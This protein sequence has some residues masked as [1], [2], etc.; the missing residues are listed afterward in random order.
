MARALVYI[1]RE[2]LAK[3]LQRTGGIPEPLQAKPQLF[4]FYCR[5]TVFLR[6]V[7]WRASGS[8]RGGSTWE[9][10]IQSHYGFS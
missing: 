7:L 5:L 2:D 9:E 1:H 6:A 8:L 3:W 4:F 10:A